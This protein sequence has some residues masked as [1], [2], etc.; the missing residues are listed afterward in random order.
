LA[1]NGNPIADKLPGFDLPA[2]W[3]AMLS[4]ALRSVFDMA[5]DDLSGQLSLREFMTAFSSEYMQKKIIDLELELPMMKEL[6]N[7]LDEDN[8]GD[9]SYMEA[10]EGL[11]KI[12]EQHKNDERT[13]RILRSVFE[14]SDVDGSGTLTKAEFVEGFTKPEIQKM[15]IRNGISFGSEDVIQLFEDIDRD[16]SD[17]VTLQEIQE[18]YLKSRDPS[19]GGDRVV[20]FL[21]KLFAEADADGSGSLTKSELMK[22]TKTSQVQK[23]LELLGLKGGD[24][25]SDAM[26]QFFESLDSEGDGLITKDELIEGYYRMRNMFRQRTLAEEEKI[27]KK[28]QLHRTSTT[29]DARGSVSQG[30]AGNRRGFKRQSAATLDK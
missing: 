13:L 16:G 11:A 27:W 29:Q 4:T 21:T 25:R 22:A 23:R 6:F 3:L 12:K 15:I 1:W 10:F 24:T 18:G 2:K 5:D 17:S 30:P 20:A 26:L 7:R 19:R 28:R 9:V 14:L 8:N